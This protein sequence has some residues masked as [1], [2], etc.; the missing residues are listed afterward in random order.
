MLCV[1]A[2]YRT[3]WGGDIGSF[4]KPVN[5]VKHENGLKGQL[6]G[7]E[8]QQPIKRTR[9]QRGPFICTLDKEESI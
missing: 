6:S 1:D 2:T 3:E 7:G 9:K 4:T 5:L 8:A